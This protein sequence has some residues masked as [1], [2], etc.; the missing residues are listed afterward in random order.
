M[1]WFGDGVTFK[2]GGKIALPSKTFKIA[3]SVKLR[4][5]T[6]LTG[7]IGA[8]GGEKPVLKL[9][10]QAYWQRGS[11][12]VFDCTAGDEDNGNVGNYKFQYLVF[13]A[14]Q[15]GVDTILSLGQRKAKN[16]E[17]EDDVDSHVRHCNFNKFGGGIKK[18]YAIYYNGRNANVQNCSFTDSGGGNSN[19]YAVC[20]GLDFTNMEDDD[21]GKNKFDSNPASSNRKNRVRN[22][23]FHTGGST[24]A[25]EVMGDYPNMGLLISNNTCDTGARL[26]D[27]RSG[28]LSGAANYS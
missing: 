16:G 22:N 8:I 5:P 9:R 4:T 18:T 26:L 1:N 11:K 28:G 24:T 3:E 27:V 2:K 13:N 20:I 6:V 12:K 25:I 23:S 17:A 19:N 14:Q 21:P 7:P 15:W 10:D